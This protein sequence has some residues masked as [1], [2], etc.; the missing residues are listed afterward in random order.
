[1]SIALTRAERKAETRR[2]LIETASELFARRG[3]E[4]TSLDEVAASVGLTKGAV[5]AHFA[6]KAALVEEVLHAHS[7]AVSGEQLLDPGHSVAESLTDIATDAASLLRKMP[8]ETV[9]LFLEFV[10]YSLRD[11][12]R[13]RRLRKELRDSRTSSGGALETAARERKQ[14]LA[15][16]GTELSTLLEAIGHG[17]ALMFAIDPNAMSSE[18]IIR[19]FAALGHGLEDTEAVSALLSRRPST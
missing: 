4:A 2:A 16:S 7:A 5:Y 6:S 18:T 3:I 9:V 1:M 17:L 10:L 19:F 15:L 11:P 8:R 12:A 13:H 14:E